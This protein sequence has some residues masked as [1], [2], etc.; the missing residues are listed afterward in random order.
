MSSAPTISLYR[1]DPAA[2]LR[3]N[4]LDRPTVML[5]GLMALSA[6]SLFICSTLRH[7]VLRSGAFDLGFFD[8][9]VYLISQG[10]QPIS[11][12]LGVHV[13]A[14]HASLILY[15][16]ALL[17]KI[18]AD[19]H[20]LL[21]AQ[22]LALSAG[23]W[24]VYRLGLLSGL[25]TRVALG[26]GCAYLMF[27]LV[28]TSN[29]FDF[30]PDV[31]IV[32]ALLWAV[33]AVREDRKLLFTCCVIVTLMCKEII[34]LTIVAMGLWLLLTEK[35]RF[36]GVFAVLAG[37][38]WFV[39]AVKVLIPAFGN[40]RNPSGLGYYAYLGGSLGEIITNFVIHPG[41]WLSKI[42]SR[43]AAQYMLLLVVPAAWGL[44]YRTMAPLLAALPAV[45]LNVL[46][47]NPAQ[48]SPFFQYS[49]PVV[50][51]MFVALIIGLASGH[52][53]LRRARS[54]VAWSVAM[55]VVGALAR[56]GKVSS[57]QA[58][59][60]DTVSHTRAAVRQIEPDA[61]VLTT[62][63]TV[64]HLSRR[65][66]VQW[67]GGVG[68]KL[69]IEDYDYILLSTSHQSLDHEDP[70]VRAVFS[71]AVMSPVFHLEYFAGD[72][73]LFKRMPKAIN[74]VAMARTE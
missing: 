73:F 62:F 16:L 66:V 18:W 26:V 21:I 50:P 30:H 14:D 64:P 10:K 52:A 55:L 65:E 32:P 29:L 17:Y 6:V 63:E 70:M 25:N 40:G 8:Q 46:S 54:I 9:T 60:L 67:V 28:L 47:E 19:P 74:V 44:H 57:S 38:V 42:F 45:M 68:P 69:P 59:D 72:V 4:P 12:L 35:R 37:L 27:P 2:L 22:A 3:R 71:Q 20:M 41:L 11:S 51:F 48:R 33:L 15:P 13:I 61:K 53:W 34:A 39:I 24:P 49:L 7:H 1:E 58:F 36:Y 43:S 31:F 56:A 5:L 23:A